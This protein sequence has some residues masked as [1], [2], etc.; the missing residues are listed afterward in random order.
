MLS[1]RGNIVKKQ[2]EELNQLKRKIRNLKY[3]QQELLELGAIPK[4]A[5]YNMPTGKGGVNSSPQEKYLI[6]V[7]EL[8]EK[9]ES[10]IEQALAKES[11]FLSSMEEL[12]ALSY[13]LLKERYVLG[14][15]LQKIIREFN[16]SESHIY[17]LYD[18]AFEKLSKNNEM[19]EDESK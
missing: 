18:K 17:R 4:R 6:R 3:E 11:E 5:N 15:P 16:Y 12:D 2:L 9:I 8:Q 14:K 7:E 10:T 1:E 13:N 19:R